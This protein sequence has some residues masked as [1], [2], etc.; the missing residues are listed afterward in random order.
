MFELND[1]LEI[2]K[3]LFFESMIYTIDNFYKH[4]VIPY[5]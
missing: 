2:K 3:E 5:E 1:N 4:N